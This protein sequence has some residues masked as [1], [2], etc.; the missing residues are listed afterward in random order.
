[1][2]IDKQ[3]PILLTDYLGN[4]LLV[5]DKSGI[6]FLPTTYELGKSEDYAFTLL[7]YSS[8]RAKYKGDE[9][10]DKEWE[11]RTNKKLL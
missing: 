8:K 6:C 2:Y 5:T 1:M 10:N 7:D 11:K 3:E 4:V 9:K